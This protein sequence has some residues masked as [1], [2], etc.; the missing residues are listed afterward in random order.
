[1]A[2][3]LDQRE[4]DRRPGLEALDEGDGRVLLLG[5]DVFFYRVRMA[6]WIRIRSLASAK[7]SPSGS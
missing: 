2:A 3:G 4:A 7:A 6:V 1:V 5:G